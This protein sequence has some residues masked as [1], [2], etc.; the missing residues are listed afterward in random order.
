M[1][2]NAMLENRKESFLEISPSLRI[3]LIRSVTLPLCLPAE[4]FAGLYCTSDF[5]HHYRNVPVAAWL[6]EP[7]DCHDADVRQ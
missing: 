4:I 3:K 7:N 1:L 5:S 6:F 2:V